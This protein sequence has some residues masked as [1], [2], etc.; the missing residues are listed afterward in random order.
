MEQHPEWHEIVDLVTPYVVRIWTQQ[1]SGTGF[2]VSVSKSSPLCAFATAAHVI[3]HAHYWGEVLP[4]LAVIRGVSQ[5]HDIAGSF[6]TIDEAKAE[7]TPAMSPPMAPE[8]EN[9]TRAIRSST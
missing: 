2:L 1:G 8:G 9:Q 4:G 6:R 3:A 5:F 7:E